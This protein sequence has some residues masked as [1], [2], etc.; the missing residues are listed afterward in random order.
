MGARDKKF[1]EGVEIEFS[2][3]DR[4]LRPRPAQPS[5]ETGSERDASKLPLIKRHPVAT[6]AYAVFMAA[7]VL[8]TIKY[9]PLLLWT[10][11]LSIYATITYVCGI[12]SL[13]RRED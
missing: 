10:G 3:N 12:S 1:T 4:S 13:D 6:G 7:M 2:R 9:Y 5:W 11:P 8:V